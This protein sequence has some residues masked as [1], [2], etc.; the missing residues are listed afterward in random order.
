[1]FYLD[2]FAVWCRTQ[3]GSILRTV[4]CAVMVLIAGVT[5]FKAVSA[6]D[7]LKATIEENS[8]VIAQDNYDINVLDQQIATVTADSNKGDIFVPNEAGGD[9]IAYLQNRYSGLAKT[10]GGSKADPEDIREGDPNGTNPYETAGL[11][12]YVS[13][14]A[15]RN[16][17]FPNMYAIYSWACDSAQP[18][19]LD[20]PG[21]V[22]GIFTCWYGSRNDAEGKL[23]SVAIGRFE[24]TTGMLN[25]ASIYRSYDG[26][27]YNNSGAGAENYSFPQYMADMLEYDRYDRD[28]IGWRSEAVTGSLASGQDPDVSTSE[29]PGES[30]QPGETDVPG[31]TEAPGETEMPG[32]E[33]DED[34]DDEGGSGF[35]L[36]SLLGGMD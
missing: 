25:G 14:A 13:S 23:L 34:E 17:W 24:P 1:M 3:K 20:M 36:G 22:P 2:D 12:T 11:V 7:G 33:E 10:G 5:V 9:A 4:I 8:A 32:T 28:E 35:D 26:R 30:E 6:G 15:A 21:N 18:V 29:T 31:G 19:I 16:A 27:G